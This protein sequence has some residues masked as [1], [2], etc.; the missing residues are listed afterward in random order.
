MGLYGT[1]G[2]AY[3]A[4]VFLLYAAA[5][6]AWLCGR[7][8]I[9]DLCR[10]W[11]AVPWQTRAAVILGAILAAAYAGTKPG[12]GNPRGGVPPGG[13]PPR[14]LTA[15][16]YASGVALIQVATGRWGVAA[17]PADAAVHGRWRRRGAAEDRSLL[18]LPDGFTFRFF[19]NRASRLWVEPG[20]RVGWGNDRLEPLAAQFSFPPEA[21]W[22][23][24]TNGAASRFWNARTATNSLLLTWE[25]ALAGRD[26]ASPVTFQAE[27][28][29]DGGFAFRYAGPNLPPAGAGWTVNG[30]TNVLPGPPAGEARW[31]GFGDL[32][33]GAAAPGDFD[34]DGLSDSAELFLHG[35]GPRAW[36]TDGDGL[37]DGEELAA[38]TD[39]LAPDTFGD[40]TNDLWRVR[41]E[42]LHSP[43]G[44]TWLAG[45][46]DAYAAL[47]VVTRLAGATGTAVLRAGD[48][49][50]PILPG[51]EAT[52]TLLLPLDR[53]IPVVLAEGIR[54]G[55]GAAAT[56]DFSGAPPCGLLPQAGN[57]RTNAD[58]GV[59]VTAARDG[60]GWN[61]FSGTLLAPS[62]T[63][64]PGHL[65]SHSLGTL[66]VH[67]E[68]G[69]AAFLLPGGGTAAALTPSEPE[70]NLPENG[71]FTVAAVG[72]RVAVGRDGWLPIG[73]RGSVP[74]H[75]CHPLGEHDPPQGEAQGDG[76]HGQ[77]PDPGLG[78]ECRCW[79]CAHP[80]GNVWA[81]PANGE[82]DGGETNRYRNVE[83]PHQTVTPTAP[84]RMTVPAEAAA[85]EGT[86]GLCG[87][88]LAS[89]W[90]GVSAL[91]RRTHNVSV[92][93]EM[94][95]YAT[96]TYTASYL[97]PSTNIGQEVLAVRSGDAFH[98][99]RMTCAGL[100]A[101]FT[102]TE[103]D[104]PEI[105]TG[106]P[107]AA[108]LRTDVLLP[109]GQ[110]CFAASAGVTVYAW[111]RTTGEYEPV[112]DPR[113]QSSGRIDIGIWRNRFCDVNRDA[114]LR[115]VAT[116]HGDGVV[117]ITYTTWGDP[118]PV[119][120]SAELRF[121][122]REVQCEP[123][124]TE[125]W[126][127]GIPYN[128]SSV[129]VGQEARYR[130]RIFPDNFPS[131]RITWSI[132]APG[133]LEFLGGNT[134]PT[135]S[136]RGLA[137]GD[138]TL[139]A[140][141]TGIMG[142]GEQDNPTMTLRVVNPSSV[143]IRAWIIGDGQQWA[144]TP[145]QVSRMVGRANQL[146]TQVGIDFR[147]ESV[148]WITNFN[149][150]VV[151]KAENSWPLTQQIVD[152]T[153]NTDGLEVYIVSNIKYATG[154][155]H[156]GGVIIS[157]AAPLVTL[158]HEIGHACGL[159]DIYDQHSESGLTL[160]A[161][162][163]REN[164]PNDWGSLSAVRYYNRTLQ[165]PDLLKRLLMY[166][167]SHETKSDISY[168]DITGLWKENVYDET[169]L[170]WNTIWHHSAAPIGFSLHGTNSPVSH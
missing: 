121:I 15:E 164:L 113:W 24:L 78:G 33:R 91:W 14:L 41:A 140:N 50:I 56:V 153:N 10:K 165:Y 30:V 138:V 158:A 144:T 11:R 136:V 163:E 29:R 117:S 87:C 139:Q 68:S 49:A 6:C 80:D 82:G 57:A 142:L 109:T 152:C 146:Y 42:S 90:D 141:I 114:E 161:T 154:L 5:F 104:I 39:P 76:D 97:G 67:S 132:S 81:T 73:G 160:S 93:P 47:T 98:R 59:T 1:Y 75:V 60:D 135:V 122:C 150:M 84:A 107:I 169:N 159:E 46:G 83:H 137:A 112:F 155:H 162:I 32:T 9:R 72:Y 92:L 2:S 89:P 147:L 74:Y 64:A 99:M 94:W 168:G 106:A 125:T 127:D 35:T 145:S 8:G 21:N 66:A 120:C 77:P 51:P 105:L 79:T 26:A 62:C 95:Y 38:G 101:S 129:A 133:C 116:Q 48:T 143:K 31:T 55:A 27:L 123:V 157:S 65:C 34:G 63:V 128:P 13:E 100:S 17:M 18:E 149:W 96:A 37:S 88:P 102:G 53:E 85:S 166:G 44:S 45:G 156:P 110:I 20:G 16:E 111:N 167:V 7:E 170:T 134:G 3:V 151:E 54:T 58:D 52:N 71:Y 131:N 61:G 148:G 126:G 69:A 23:L 40:G 118:I 22:N 19:S 36:D 43:T 25:N 86:C 4:A 103:A 28:F 12:G 70:V 108:T 115:V 124:N 130:I 119:E